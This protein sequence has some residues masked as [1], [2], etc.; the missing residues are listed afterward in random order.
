MEAI[1]LRK[2][3]H[4][5]IDISTEAKLKEV[6]HLLQDEEYSETF[7]AM[8][9]DEFNQYQK[10]GEVISLKEINNLIEQLLH[11]KK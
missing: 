4:T 3:L 8:L 1:T 5:L 2:K 7:K 9:D 6:Y 11:P 10:N